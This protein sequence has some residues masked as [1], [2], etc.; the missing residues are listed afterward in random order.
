MKE[1]FKFLFRFFHGWRRKI[2]GMTLVFA[3]ILVVGWARSDRMYGFICLG[4]NP[5]HLTVASMGGEFS[6]FWKTTTP[7]S[8][9][10]IS[11]QSGEVTELM[12]YRIGTD[13]KREHHD[14]WENYDIDWR[15]DMMGFHFGAAVLPTDGTRLTVRV[16]TY[17]FPYYSIEMDALYGRTHLPAQPCAL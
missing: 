17:V 6:C 1:F 12:P 15:F 3:C 5:T 9:S 4:G 2:G 13:G 11:W 10:Q 16:V 7:T 8:Q 14:R